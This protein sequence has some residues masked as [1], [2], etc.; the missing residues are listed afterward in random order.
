ML[1]PE[2]DRPPDPAGKGPLGW[3]CAMGDATAHPVVKNNET[4]KKSLHI[5]MSKI[6]PVSGERTFES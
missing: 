3:D 1:V 2:E 6:A 4:A 5:N